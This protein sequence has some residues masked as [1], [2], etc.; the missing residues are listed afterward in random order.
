MPVFSIIVPSY[1]SGHTL[2]DCLTSLCSQSFKDF[3]IL[4]M[5][6]LSADNTIAVANSFQDS[7]IKIFSER[8]SGIYDAMNKG[9]ARCKGDWLY[10]LGS[11]DS[12]YDKDVLKAVFSM[13]EGTDVLYGNV[14]ST[15]FQGPYDGEFNA[16]K[17]YDKNICHQAIFC[18]KKVFE[19]VGSFDTGYKTMADWAH[20]IRW[21]LD[22]RITKKF[23]DIIVANYADNGFSSTTV[24][25]LFFKNRPELFLKAGDGRLSRDQKLMLYGAAAWQRKHAGEWLTGIKYKLLYLFTKYV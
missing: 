13:Q 4:L 12:L 3:E 14:I 11:D 7:R 15:R 8:D 1:N 21:F 19:L 18:R 16:A 2:G 22:D 25:H 5:D 23:I 10:F 9:I 17:L 20:N 24:D 6:G